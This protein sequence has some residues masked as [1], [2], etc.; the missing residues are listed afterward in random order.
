MIDLLIA[1]TLL[2]L[3]T[4]WAD[5]MRALERANVC[6]RDMCTRA[7]LSLLDDTVALAARRLIRTGQGRWALR[8]T[9]VFDYCADGRSR[10]S[11][12]VILHGYRL[13]SCGL[14]P[15]TGAG[16]PGSEL[17]RESP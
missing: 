15:E 13:E 2:L 8:R 6:A 7:G 1:G 11:G 4:A 17:D 16:A 14:A 5:G 10:L 12:F 3:G 9:Y